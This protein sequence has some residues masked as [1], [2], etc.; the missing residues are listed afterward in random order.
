[1][2]NILFILLSLLF[3]SCSKEEE[4]KCCWTFKIRVATYTY[5]GQ[6]EKMSATF[7][8]KKICDLTESEANEKKEEIYNVSYGSQG[9]YRVKIVTEVVAMGKSR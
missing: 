4:E 9:G 6:T 7:L 8:D 3:L 2:K 5:K 1:M